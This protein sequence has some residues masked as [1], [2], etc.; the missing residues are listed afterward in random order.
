MIAFLG[1]QPAHKDLIHMDKSILHFRSTTGS[2][3]LAHPRFNWTNIALLV[4]RVTKSNFSEEFQPLKTNAKLRDASWIY[5]ALDH[6][7]KYP[8]E[9]RMDLTKSRWD[10]NLI[11][12]VDDLLQALVHARGL[13]QKPSEGTLQVILHALSLVGCNVSRLAF[14]V[15]YY[16]QHWFGDETLKTVLLRNSTIALMGQVAL[17][18]LE[19]MEGPY[20]SI[21]DKLSSTN[22]W[23]LILRNDPLVWLDFVLAMTPGKAHIKKVQAIT[24]RIWDTDFSRTTPYRFRSHVEETIGCIV[25][26]L[27]KLWITFQFT[28]TFINFLT[29]LRLVKCSLSIAVQIWHGGFKKNVED[30]LSPLF[31]RILLEHFG[32]ALLVAAYSSRTVL[33]TRQIGGE[34]ST[35]AADITG[36]LETVMEI[37]EKIARHIK[38][39]MGNLLGLPESLSIT[40]AWSTFQADIESKIQDLEESLHGIFRRPQEIPGGPEI[41]S[42]QEIEIPGSP[43]HHPLTLTPLVS[44][45]PRLSTEELPLIPYHEPEPTGVLLRPAAFEHW[46]HTHWQNWQPD[47]DIIS[48]YDHN[49]DWQLPQLPQLQDSPNHDTPADTVI[50]PYGST[51]SDAAG[52][53]VLEELERLALVGW[54]QVGS[55]NEMDPGNT[56]EERNLSQSGQSIRSNSP[57]L[58]GPEFGPPNEI[59]PG[60]TE[61]ERDISELEQSIRNDS[62][63]LFGPPSPRS[64]SPGESID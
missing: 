9:S 27:S 57:D 38:G 1:S 21:V 6:V 5:E 56:E 18:Y 61:G 50:P 25:G 24:R 54:S 2:S 53:A 44:A 41:G 23:K 16:S 59:D 17:K 31:R 8:A 19:Y 60:A 32:D 46:G 34:V 51:R 55:P 43:N 15:L 64:G 30:K 10:A 11:L 22:D 29:F 35:A 47:P 45:N 7:I 62:P 36:C 13:H 14:F 33:E 37:L 12:V 40:E 48:I 49:S 58:S 3:S 39:D 4:V 28:G 20:V 63:S 26:A 52:Q 42:A